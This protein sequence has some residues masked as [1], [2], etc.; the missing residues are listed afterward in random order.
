VKQFQADYLKLTGQ[1]TIPSGAAYA[2]YYYD[3]LYLLIKA[4]ETA[5]TVTDGAKIADA[6]RKTTITGLYGPVRF[7]DTDNAL[8]GKFPIS[9]VNNGQ[10]TT[11]YYSTT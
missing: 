5:G 10:T 9:Y 2:P 7:E 4:I 11:Q 1:S 6:V 8:I 3:P